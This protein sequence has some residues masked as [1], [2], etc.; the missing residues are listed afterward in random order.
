MCKVTGR[1]KEIRTSWITVAG[2]ETVCF[3]P[4]LQ[5]ICSTQTPSRAIISQTALDG[6]CR[7]VE[8][9]TGFSNLREEENPTEIR[10]PQSCWQHSGSQHMKDPPE[11]ANENESNG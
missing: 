6:K 4:F 1:Q 2:R 7:R 8:E 9:V 3:F 5:L 11:I 10:R